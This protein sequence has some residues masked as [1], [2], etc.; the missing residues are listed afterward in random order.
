M[1]AETSPA[2]PPRLQWAD[3]AAR[4]RFFY[5]VWP[6][7][8]TRPALAALAADAARRAGGRA[9]KREN[10]HLT[11]AFVGEVAGEQREVLQAIGAGAANGTAPCSLVLDRIGSFRDSGVVWLGASEAPPALV[12]LAAGLAG[13]LHDAGLRAER[14]AFR[15]H[16][17]VAR[18]CPRPLMEDLAAPITW[19][20]DTLTLV[21][22]ELRTDGPRYAIVA[23]W[24]LAGGGQS[25][26]GTV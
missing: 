13:R 22:S 26:T 2:A 16:I 15:P 12:G 19:E 18:R 8:A 9:A 11:L 24:P 14:R 6:A 4:L 1:N 23:R 25:A 7:G 21:T 20:I 3:A 17:T 5:A 10:L